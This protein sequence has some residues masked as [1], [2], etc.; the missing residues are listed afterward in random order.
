M[1]KLWMIVGV[2][3]MLAGCA[4]SRRDLNPVTGAVIGG[5]TGAVVGGIA[6]KSVGGAFAGGF[7]GAA[8]GALIGTAV[9]HDRR[10][11]VRTRTGR[12]RWVRCY[13]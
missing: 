6:S 8:A 1:R 9:S 13:H 2:A 5:G 10:C 4:D 12:V 7:I 11:Y 3:M